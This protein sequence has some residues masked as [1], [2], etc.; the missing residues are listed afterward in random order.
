MYIFVNTDD[1]CNWHT[2][3]LFPPRG[4]GWETTLSTVTFIYRTRPFST[5]CSAESDRVR[6]GHYRAVYVYVYIGLYGV[7]VFSQMKT[8]RAVGSSYR[9]PVVWQC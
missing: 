7:R 5:R 3:A 6:A 1:E 8:G 9:R 4:G 2:A